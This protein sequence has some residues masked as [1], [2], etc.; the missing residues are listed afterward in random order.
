M[1]LASLPHR[2]GPPKIQI[3]V[4]DLGATGVVRNAIAIANLAAASG[5]RVR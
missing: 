2:A 4:S 3:F 5:F 1:N